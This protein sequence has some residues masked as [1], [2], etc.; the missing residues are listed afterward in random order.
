MRTAALLGLCLLP[1]F[2]APLPREVRFVSG[3]VN[4]ARIG[5]VAIY[6]DP[7]KGAK[8]VLFTHAR[9]DLVAAGAEAVAR[10]A[11]AIVPAAER[12]LF[13]DPAAFWADMEKSRFHDYA[14]RSTKVPVEPVAV[15]RAVRG[16]ETLD[17]DGVRC[18][19][20]DTSGYTPGS[21][22]YICQAGGRRIAF[23]GDLILEDGRIADLY[24][25]QDAIPEAKVRGYHGYAA[26]TGALVESLRR[27]AAARPDAIVPVRGGVIDD[28]QTAIATLIR[29]VQA[30]MANHFSTDA[31]LWY[32]GPE[33][34][35]LRS[36]AVLE[37]APVD[38][39][40]MAEQRAVPDWIQIFSNCRLIVSKSGAAFLVDAGAKGIGE[41]LE[42]QQQQ[43]R[44]S[45]LEG[46]WLTHYHD[47]HT[48]YA[49]QTADA[50]HAP[51][52]AT[53]GMLDI[54][55][56]PGSYRMPCLTTGPVHAKGQPDGRSMR[57]HEFEFTFFDFPGQT[58]YHGGLLAR[59]DGG[60][61]VFFAGDSFT[62]SG[63]D[64]YS[65]PNRN[66]LREG[67]GFMK[68]LS[69]L[70]RSRDAW[71]INEH[72]VPMFRFPAAQ[73]DRMK[74]ALAARVGLLRGLSPWPD[75]NFLIDENWARMYP[76][77]QAADAGAELDLEMRIT[78][79]STE[80]RVFD[81][82]WHVPAGLR[83]E[84]AER[85]VKIAAHG[86]GAARARMRAVK[87][88]LHIPTADVRFGDFELRQFAEAMVRVR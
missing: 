36:R 53:P 40:P 45:K 60:E 49:Q 71:L 13:A 61:S 37:G 11:A 38:S 65:I 42:K 67:E 29:R 32:W 64:D 2:A 57:W 17:L 87:P 9:R 4:R 46:L 35:R 59:R 18:E 85:R 25:L 56:H 73:Y 27:I 48:D 88:G 44:F 52:Y 41:Y 12:E 5:T 69:V 75:G 70:D 33:N 31:L 79:H 68:C 1:A 72:V 19:V 50:F 30:V 23:T 34:L 82:N 66:I 54:L 84:R 26:R 63:I 10:G 55:E 15:A 81:L 14:Q 47:D 74:T 7:A 28:P 58:I 16:G 76:Y 51:L 86:E 8:H 78:N 22:S 80:D 3:P 39:M 21:V 20:L 24:S 6:A 62:P 43:G 77:G 83:L